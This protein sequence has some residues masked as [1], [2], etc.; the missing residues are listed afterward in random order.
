MIGRWRSSCAALYEQ[1]GFE[2]TRE[3]EVLSLP[4][5]ETEADAEEVEIEKALGLIARRREGPEPWQREG[6]TVVNFVRRDPPPQGLRAGEAA[7]V[8]GRDGGRIALL[9]AA[10]DASGL[11]ALLS[12][13]RRRGTVLA[14]NYP[15]GG[16]IS[17]A[18]HAAGADVVVRQ[19]EMS[20]A[21]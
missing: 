14:S 16:A 19:L 17:A 10:G 3:L 7:G 13:L 1:L 6:A 21:F 11:V 4:S 20:L 5:A 2:V 9:Q 15:A 18:L 12:A 8:C